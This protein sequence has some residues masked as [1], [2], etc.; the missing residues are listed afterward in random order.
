MNSMDY[1]GI[2]P[3]TVGAG[4]GNPKHVR[5]TSA[6]KAFFLRLQFINGGRCEGSR[7]ACRRP[8]WPV[9]H[10]SHLS[11]ALVVENE[12]AVSNQLGVPL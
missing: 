7:K 11:A 5:R 4:R 12:A 8:N 2:V 6:T 9:F 1:A 3:A 10:T